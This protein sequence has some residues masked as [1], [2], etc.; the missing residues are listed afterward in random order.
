MEVTDKECVKTHCVGDRFANAS[1]FECDSERI[2]DECHITSCDVGYYLY[3]GV[4]H[5]NTDAHCGSHENSCLNSED[6]PYPE[7]VKTMKCGA[8]G[9]CFIMECKDEAE[10]NLGVCRKTV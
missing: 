5:E 2:N 9:Q 1:N 8:D 6:N 7:L 3:G 4:C 10:L